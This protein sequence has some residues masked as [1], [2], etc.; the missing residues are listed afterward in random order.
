MPYSL[1]RPSSNFTS[2]PTTS[3]SSNHKKDST[4][5][6]LRKIWVEHE[7]LFG[8]LFARRV[9]LLTRERFTF[10]VDAFIETPMLFI[11]SH[12]DGKEIQGVGLQRRRGSNGPQRADELHLLNWEPVYGR[13]GERGEPLHSG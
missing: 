6:G 2:K 9:S 4:E 1:Y 3:L 8:K 10:P 12:R 11:E 5:R 13:D 7:R